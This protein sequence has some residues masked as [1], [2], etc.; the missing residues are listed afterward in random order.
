MCKI[1]KWTCFNVITGCLHNHVL[2]SS[3]IKWEIYGYRRNNSTKWLTHIN[4]YCLQT[5]KSTG[6][7]SSFHDK[8]TIISDWWKEAPGN[9]HTR[10]N[11]VVRYRDKSPVTGH[12]VITF[13]VPTFWKIVVPLPSV[14]N[15]HNPSEHCNLL[16][17]RQSVTCQMTWAFSNT[18]VRTSHLAFFHIQCVCSHYSVR[19]P[20]VET[21]SLFFQIGKWTRKH[22]HTRV[23]TLIVATIYLQLIQNRYMFQCFLHLR[24]QVEVTRA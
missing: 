2:F 17:Q 7:P 11:K 9:N 22:L 5:I 1:N 8:V 18:A 15:T 3:H 13:V 24:N 20:N 10:E 4:R 19:L 14:V 21:L 16:I 23:G 6:M 12:C